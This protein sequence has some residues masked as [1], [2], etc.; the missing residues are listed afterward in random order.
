M[1]RDHVFSHCS[2][3][4]IIV[5]VADWRDFD[6]A[7]SRLG[8]AEFEA[9][10]ASMPAKTGGRSNVTCS[11]LSAG[12]T[13]IPPAK[14]SVAPQENKPVY[15]LEEYIYKWNSRPEIHSVCYTAPRL[16]RDNLTLMRPILIIPGRGALRKSLVGIDSRQEKAVPIDGQETE[17]QDPAAKKLSLYRPFQNATRRKCIRCGH[18]HQWAE[19][20]IHTF[21]RKGGKKF[22]GRNRQLAGATE[23][24]HLAIPGQLTPEFKAANTP[25]TALTC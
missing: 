14:I 4:E 21:H 7:R 9:I 5:S 25:S 3:C 17:Q 19:F 1:I 23:R 15:R 16:L 8:P 18:A 6:H 20:G 10:P 11:D 22:V 12:T 13:T 24:W 2:K